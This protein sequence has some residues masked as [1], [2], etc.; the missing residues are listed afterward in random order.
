MF[1][2]VLAVNCAAHAVAF[3]PNYYRVVSDL[4]L[5]ITYDTVAALLRFYLTHG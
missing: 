4:T 5:R 1:L 3:V 2:S